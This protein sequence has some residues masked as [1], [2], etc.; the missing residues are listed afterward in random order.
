MKHYSI[1]YSLVYEAACDLS[2]AYEKLLADD[3]QIAK[4]LIGYAKDKLDRFTSQD[5]LVEDYDCAD[6]LIKLSDTCLLDE[7]YNDSDYETEDYFLGSEEDPDEIQEGSEED[8][9]T[10]EPQSCTECDL[11]DLIDHPICERCEHNDRT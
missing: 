8:A 7:M 9:D 11:N 5:N 2:R 1:D 10:G 3:I 4:V 6:P